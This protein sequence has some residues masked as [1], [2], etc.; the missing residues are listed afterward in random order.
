M[1][2]D[3][4]PKE[5]RPPGWYSDPNTGDLR[6]WD[7]RPWT[8]EA[9]PNAG[10][11]WRRWILSSQLSLRINRWVRNAAAVAL[12]IA[13]GIV[14]FTLATGRAISG[15]GWLL[16]PAIPV[17]VFGQFWVIA[18]LSARQPKRSRG[19]RARMA[20]RSFNARTLFFGGVSRRTGYLLIA[21]FYIGC[22]AA[23]TAFVFSPAGNPTRGYAGCPYALN[24]HGSIECVSRS[25]YE[26]AR[27][28]SQRAF[29]GVLS[30]FFVIHFGVTA[31]EVNRRRGDGTDPAAPPTSDT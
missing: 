9:R 28:A 13:F 8:S 21:L 7:G 26:R 4:E 5:L 10:L 18:A 14:A 16:I 24:Q 31:G 3:E 30:G 6:W 2:G 29:A 15:L 19:L 27:T 11:G 23:V 25:T 1:N 22:L 20:M 12:T 17:L